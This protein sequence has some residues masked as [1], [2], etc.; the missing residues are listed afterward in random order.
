MTAPAL[1]NAPQ[2]GST[3]LIQQPGIAQQLAPLIDALAQHQLARAQIESYKSL[4]EERKLKAAQ[5]AQDTQDAADAAKAFYGH[6]SGSEQ[7]LK[8]AQAKEGQ[9]PPHSGVDETSGM[10]MPL[11]QFERG[12]SPK[13]HALY[14]GM[15]ESHNKALQEV[16]T[17]A[18]DKVKTDHEQVLTDIARAGLMR[19]TAVKAALG[20]YAGTLDKPSQQ[21]KAIAEVA[22]LGDLTGAEG[23]ARTFNLGND[24]YKHF[25]RPDGFVGILD[26]K[27]GTTQK[28]E[29]V[30]Q[31]VAPNQEA[32]QRGAQ[33]VVDL[34]DEQSRLIQQ[35]GLG[36]SKNPSLAQMAQTARVLG[37]PT[38]AI[39]NAFRTDPQQ[40]TQMLKTRFAHNYVGL[41]PHSRSAANLLTNLTESYWAPGGSSEPTLARAE[42]DR[43]RLR[44]MLDQV[45]KGKMDLSKIP[46]FAEAAQAAVAEGQQPPA[47]GMGQP[48]V[49]PNPADWSQGVPP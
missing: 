34:L 6:I 4:T 23:L 28:G 38:E 45:A 24:R 31:K 44:G 11:P 21:A 32:V 46:G 10:L 7:R 47:G 17:A 9:P 19:D 37:V 18:A 39:A 35:T 49:L 40:I 8:P 13:A 14:L 26:S 48:A 42:R 27:L 12:L 43:K 2:I 33:T 15:I 41:L 22:A 36:A 20:K 5:Q 16:L 30:G 29:F 1:P 25:L 3:G